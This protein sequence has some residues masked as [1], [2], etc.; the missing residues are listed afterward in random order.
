[1]RPRLFLQ[2]FDSK[3]VCQSEGREVSRVKRSGKLLLSLNVATKGTVSAVPLHACSPHT[4]L[5]GSQRECSLIG[6][7]GTHF[8]L[9]L[10]SYY[11]AGMQNFG[12]A[13]KD[14]PH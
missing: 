9:L 8:F 13:I 5:R 11:C 10:F 7:A 4:A 14:G 2:F 1:M 6:N 12:Y 3:F